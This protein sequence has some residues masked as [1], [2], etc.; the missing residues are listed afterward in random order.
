MIATACIADEHIETSAAGL[1]AASDRRLAHLLASILALTL[2][3]EASA[4]C[5]AAP[6]Q[7]NAGRVAHRAGSTRRRLAS[8]FGEIEVKVPRLGAPGHRPAMLPG[9]LGNLDHLA[10][11]LLCLAAGRNSWSAARQLLDQLRRL[12]GEAEWLTQ[13]A[14]RIVALADLTRHPLLPMSASVLHIA[15]LDAAA[16]CSLPGI[17][18]VQAVGLRD[19]RIITWFAALPAQD[20]GAWPRLAQALHEHG[21]LEVRR[22][23]VRGDAACLDA[24]RA[25]WPDA[26]PG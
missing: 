12:H 26:E 2:E 15:A 20:G 4:A 9:R 19:R 13:L 17:H 11:P 10:A 25:R 14:Q 16:S 7:R 1:A 23:D 8:P 5:Q 6:F 3:A 22:L 21:L 24:L 18:R